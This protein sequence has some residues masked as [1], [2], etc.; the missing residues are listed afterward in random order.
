VQKGPISGEY[1]T[2]AG[3]ISQNLPGNLDGVIGLELVLADASIA[4]VGAGGTVD[5]PVFYRYFGPDFTG[6]FCGDCGSLGI[7]TEVI[8]RLVPERP[9]SFASFSFETPQALV[10]AMSTLGKANLGLRLF[11]MDPDKNTETTKVD[12]KTALQVIGAV[13]GKGGNPLAR[14]GDL[15]QLA[16]AGF[17]MG[18]AGWT[19]HATAEAPTQPAADSVIAEARRLLRGSCVEVDNVLPKTLHTKPYS[20]RGFVG[21]Q[22]ERWVP[23]H[24]ILAPSRA[25]AAIGAITDYLAANAARLEQAGVTTGY[26][27]SGMG[28]Y[29]CMEPMFYWRDALDP[30]HLR[31]LSERNRQRFGDRP[32][33]PK[34]RELVQE[35][36]A[37]IRT[38]FRGSGALHAQ[39]ARYYD[40]TGVLEPGAADLA[41]RLKKQLDPTGIMNPGALGL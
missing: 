41:A 5:T 7:K 18:A 36:R 35:M 1:S 6:M 29:V 17:S 23:I 21:R 10:T 26:V 31:H 37:E 22:G 38:I 16:R 8:L 34:A 32:E 28:P 27:F 39:L 15:I 3:A 13:L 12:F 33:N 2:I 19:L 40:Y 4:R 20:V 24:G 14:I 11:G 25:L 9:A 30:I